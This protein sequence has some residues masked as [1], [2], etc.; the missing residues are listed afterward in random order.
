MNPLEDLVTKDQTTLIEKKGFISKANA[1]KPEKYIEI[2]QEKRNDFSSQIMSDEVEELKQQ[3]KSALKEIEDLRLENREMKKEMQRLSSSAEENAFLLKTAQFTDRLL[4]EM[5]ERD[6]KVHVGRTHATLENYG[7]ERDFSHSGNP[8][9]SQTVLHKSMQR[10][11]GFLNRSARRKASLPLKLIGAKL[12]EIT[13]SV[14]NVAMDPDSGGETLS[15]TTAPGFIDYE[16][17][18]PNLSDQFEV[19]EQLIIPAHSSEALLLKAQLLSTKYRGK[20]HS[21]V[22]PLWKNSGAKC[23]M[24]LRTL[25][26]KYLRGMKLGKRKKFQI[27]NHAR[28]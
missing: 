16:H 2:T 26:T 22:T 27:A 13:R 9:L 17:T 21:G 3:L 4:R 10:K 25:K 19:E 11:E 24:V 14:E 28:S 23:F 18:Y 1:H 12:K 15:Q 7:L 8:E 20:F 6:A 5:R